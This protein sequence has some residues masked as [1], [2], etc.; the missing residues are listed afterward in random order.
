MKPPQSSNNSVSLE[1]PLAR[2]PAIKPQ[3]EGEKNDMVAFILILVVNR[4]QL[5]SKESL[6]VELHSASVVSRELKEK[7][8]KVRTKLARWKCRDSIPGH[9]RRPTWHWLRT[10]SC[11]GGR[12]QQ[13]LRRWV[14]G[15]KR[16]D[17]RK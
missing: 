2:C 4:L 5:F 7:R 9:F 14:R 3:Q 16:Q 8:E 6:H 10:S 11:C 15:H 12:T 13:D 1:Q 17:R